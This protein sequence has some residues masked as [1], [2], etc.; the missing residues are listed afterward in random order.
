MSRYDFEFISHYDGVSDY[1]LYID[2]KSDTRFKV[3]VATRRCFYQDNSRALKAEL[4]AFNNMKREEHAKAKAKY[5][6]LVGEFE[7]YVC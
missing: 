1:R 5:P 7:E 3:E 4:A 6:D 2:G